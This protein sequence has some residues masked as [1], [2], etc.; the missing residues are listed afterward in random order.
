MRIVR[1]RLAPE[2][3]WP[4]LPN[5]MEDHPLLALG[6]HD[7]LGVERPGGAPNI[8]GD[9]QL[10][11]A[12]KTS[13]RGWFCENTGEPKP[14]DPVMALAR[15]LS[16]TEGSESSVSSSNALLPRCL[17]KSSMSELFGLMDEGRWIGVGRVM[18]AGELMESNVFLSDE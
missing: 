12:P 4:K 18:G 16:G 14:R 10:L 5:G 1:G 6:F 15:R 13:M 17:L 8:E 7:E 3:R 11:F 9:V 2:G